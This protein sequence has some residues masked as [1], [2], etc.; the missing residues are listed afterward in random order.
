MVDDY[1]FS[2]PTSMT[3]CYNPYAVKF[4]R[5]NFLPHA[6]VDVC[7]PKK[8]YIVREGYTRGVRNEREVRR[9]F[10]DQGWALIAPETL[11]INEQ[12]TLFAGAE[13]IAG[14]HGSA[15]TNLVWCSPGC[16]VLEFAP[17]NFLAGA[18]EIVAKI[19]HLPHGFI[20]CEAD[21]HSQV[22]I[23]INLLAKT[24]KQQ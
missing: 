14:I 11:S 5:D 6:S 22:R 10:E 12:I 24:L 3:G 17:E 21:P 23:D 1:F 13:A 2:S 15:L 8:F 4:L 18:F 19:L 9:F 20:I 7:F 16:R